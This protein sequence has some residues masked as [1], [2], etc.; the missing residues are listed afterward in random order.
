MTNEDTATMP[1][2]PAER[3]DTDI[4]AAEHAIG[5][6]IATNHKNAKHMANSV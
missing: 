6:D 3:T 2:L 5:V 1:D 4:T